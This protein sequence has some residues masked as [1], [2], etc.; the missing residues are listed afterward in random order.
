MVAEYIIEAALDESCSDG[1]SAVG[2]TTN[3]QNGSR[4][5]KNPTAEMLAEAEE[6]NM[7]M[8]GM[9]FIEKGS[10]VKRGK[11]LVPKTITVS[12]FITGGKEIDL[13]SADFVV[14]VTTI[15]MKDFFGGIELTVPLGVRV[16]EE[17]VGFLSDTHVTK[18]LANADCETGPLIILKGM[19]ILSDLSVKVNDKVPP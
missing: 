10:G 7:R 9:I 11:F 5:Y 13:S 1:S 8:G 6:K 3:A 18:K 19:H 15:Y 12:Q 4:Y 17:S 14:P 2:D 16:E